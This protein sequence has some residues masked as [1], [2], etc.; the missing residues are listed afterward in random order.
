MMLKKIGIICLALFLGFALLP[1]LT[2]AQSTAFLET[3]V[4][5]LESETIQLRSQ[6][7]RIES[8]LAQLAGGR[9]PSN[10]PAPSIP[11]RSN[12]QVSSSDP[13]FDRLATLVIELK[14]RV[15]SLEAQVAELKKQRR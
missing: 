6:L 7:S 3:R 12:R 9:V 5:R 8:Q 15:Q 13:L 4:S 11:S 2:L 1:R 10:R 14:Q